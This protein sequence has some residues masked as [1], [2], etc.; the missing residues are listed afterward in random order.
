MNFLFVMKFWTDGQP[1]SSRI[2]NVEY[3]LPKMNKLSKFLNER[4]VSCESKIYDF[5]PTKIINESIHRP[6]PLGEYKKAQKTNVIIN[7]HPNF[8]YMFMFDCDAFFVDEDFEKIFELTSKLNK[9]K[10][11]TFDLAKLDEST[12]EKI[13]NNETINFYEENCWYAYAG[14]KHVGPLGNGTSGGLGGVYLCDLD[15]LR[16]NGGFDESYVGWGGEDG[17]MMNRITYSGKEYEL[18]PQRGFVPFHLPH[19]CDWSNEK[20]SKRFI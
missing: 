17:D 6:Y 9:R 19:F 12:V 10:I 2:R 7:E 18:I 5:S 20:Y 14:E 3:T 13:K 15:L 16:E 8:D 11:V 4:G 1:N